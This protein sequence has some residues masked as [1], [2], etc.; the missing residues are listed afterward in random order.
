MGFFKQL[1]F[2]KKYKNIKFKHQFISSIT[3]LIK[4]LVLCLL[5]GALVGSASAGFLITLEW[6]TDNR[7]QNIWLI[8]GLPLAG[9]IIGF[10]YYH[11]GKGLED[12]SKLLIKTMQTPQKIIPFKMAPLVYA[13]TMITHFFGGSAGREGTALQMAGAISDQLSKPFKLDSE[14]RKILLMAAVAAGFGSVFGTPLAGAVFGLELGFAGRLNYKT[15]VA[16]FMAAIFA[17][18]IAHLWGAPHTFYQIG[19]VPELNFTRVMYVLVA[20]LLFG[21]CAKFFVFTK[22]Q[23]GD[24]INSKIAY[25]PFRPFLGGIVVLILFLLLGTTQYLGLGIP[26][27]LSSFEQILPFQVFAL[28]ILF[29][30][31]TL[32]FGFKGGEVT[33]LFFIGATLGSAL[34]LFI[35]LPFGL[36][37]GMGF[38]AV[39]AGATKTPLAC[40]VMGIELFGINSVVYIGLACSVA[41]LFSGKKSIYNY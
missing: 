34:A 41:F 21:W 16:T 9:L 29:T 22:H 23:L 15:I 3:N 18:L 13:G 8:Y 4:W 19:L 5:V 26:T 30:V 6:A 33:P 27:I 2:F 38:V 14:D 12:G 40:L 24:F 17:D 36:L 35:P 1:K 39:F 11:G 32:S 7:E 37:A 28:K 10:L 31:I 25:P 20:G